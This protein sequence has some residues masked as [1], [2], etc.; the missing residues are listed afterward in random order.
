MWSE[1]DK[2]HLEK[3][4]GRIVKKYFP[5]ARIKVIPLEYGLA[6]DVKSTKYMEGPDVIKL[7]EEIEEY[8]KNYK[9][10]KISQ[11]ADVQKRTRIFDVLDFGNKITITLELTG[12]EPE[13]VK[14]V[15]VGRDSVTI[16][17]KDGTYRGFGIPEIPPIKPETIKYT[18]VNNVLD[19]EVEK[20]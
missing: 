16:Y 1:E 18:L 2:K 20:K 10:R 15:D 12:I 17:K 5:E 9:L 13:D 14:R 6:V 8:I 7:E 11:T 3:E 4:L 19:V